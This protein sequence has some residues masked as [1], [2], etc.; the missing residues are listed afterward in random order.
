MVTDSGMM[1]TDSGPG[2]DSGM[3]G[4]DSGTPGGS[5]AAPMVTSVC[6][7]QAVVRVRALLGAGMASMTGTL[8]ANLYH[9]NL[10]GGASGGFRHTGGSRAGVTISDT[11]AAEVHFDMCAEGEMWSEENCGYNLWVYLDRNGNSALDAGE[12]AGR[13]EVDV[14]C[15]DSAAGCHTV[16]LGC[17][18][19]MSCAAFT[20][21]GSCSCRSPNCAGIGSAG[22]IS[23]CS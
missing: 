1:G 6:L 8:R 15:H 17:T 14:N 20:D 10:G 23:T 22:R 11:T 19:G 7:P 18:A 3:M 9:M 4:T 2:V 5:C 12:P 13:T 21:P 16:V